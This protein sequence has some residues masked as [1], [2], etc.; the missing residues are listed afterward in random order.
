MDIRY[1]G[2]G[3]RKKPSEGFVILYI[4]ITVI[5][6]LFLRHWALEGGTDNNIQEVYQD[7]ELQSVTYQEDSDN[8]IE[9]SGDVSSDTA[10]NNASATLRF[11]SRKLLD[12]HYDKHG[13]DMGFDSPASYEAAAAA[14]VVNPE[15][16]HKTEAEDGDDIYYVE[17]TNEFVV[18]STDGYIRTY[19]LPDKG[20]AYYDKQ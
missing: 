1:K 18:V 4:A 5:L 2:S 13:R 7:V 11:R 6:G 15:A 14:V 12:Q 20:K 9:E 17:S 10:E 3:N 16:L 19:F 8:V